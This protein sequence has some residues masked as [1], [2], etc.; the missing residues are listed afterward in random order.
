M[1]QIIKN[2]ATK[3][4]KKTKQWEEDGIRIPGEMC[5]NL[6]RINGRIKLQKQHEGE[7]TPPV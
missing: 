6:S 1:L 7:I 5:S 2:Y 3:W 4:G